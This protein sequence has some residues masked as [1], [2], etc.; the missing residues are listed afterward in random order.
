MTRGALIIQRDLI[1][2]TAF[3]V[4]W[5][6]PMAYRGLTNRPM[7]GLPRLLTYLHNV[8][9]L[10]PTAMPYWRVDYVLIRPEGSDAW[11]ALPEAEYFRMTPFGHRTRL[12]QLMNISLTP[13][14]HAR[15]AEAAAWIRARYI[16]RHPQRPRP[17]AVRFVGAQYRTGRDA[18]RGPWRTPPLE[19]FH[20]EE[21]FILSTH[22]FPPS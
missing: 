18:P 6:G 15:R 22:D 11:T 9:A 1:G 10:F 16:A 21:S 3:L 12:H 4:L 13:G 5:L 8:S 19:S 17:A 14:G 20:P 7:P 2:L